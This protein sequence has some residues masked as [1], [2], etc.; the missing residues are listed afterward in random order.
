MMKNHIVYC[1][2]CRFFVGAWDKGDYFICAHDEKH[3][4]MKKE[5]NKNDK[6]GSNNKHIN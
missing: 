3:K 4:I 5:D 2:K 1:P 6:E